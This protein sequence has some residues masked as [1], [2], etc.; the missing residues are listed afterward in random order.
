MHQIN[1]TSTCMPAYTCAAAGRCIRVHLTEH[2]VDF[3]LPRVDIACAL[4]RVGVHLDYSDTKRTDYKYKPPRSKLGQG[5]PC[6]RP[7]LRDALL[8]PW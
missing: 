3:R 6:R 8:P 2:V 4:P 1:T 7:R 5:E